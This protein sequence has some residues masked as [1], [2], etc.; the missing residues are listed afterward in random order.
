VGVARLRVTN[1]AQRKVE[2]VNGDW[3]RCRKWGGAWIRVRKL[4]AK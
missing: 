3:K 2:V 4:T 1:L